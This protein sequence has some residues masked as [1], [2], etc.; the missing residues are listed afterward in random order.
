V[1]SAQQQ[2]AQLGMQHLRAPHG[3]ASPPRYTIPAPITTHWSP[4]HT[5]LAINANW[6]P[7]HTVSPTDLSNLVASDRQRRASLAI[8]PAQL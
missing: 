6:S 5:P 1:L 2:Q 7:P 4:P 8:V 3:G